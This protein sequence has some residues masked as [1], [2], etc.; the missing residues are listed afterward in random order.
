MKALAGV[1]ARFVAV[2]LGGADDIADGDVLDAAS[3]A[4]EEH[5]LWLEMGD[6]ALGGLGGALTAGAD[7]SDGDPVGGR[8]RRRL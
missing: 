6:G 3:D 2:D 4:D 5:E 7:F 8:G 1:L